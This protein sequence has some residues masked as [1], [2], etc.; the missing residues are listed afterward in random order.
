M[1]KEFTLRSGAKLKVDDEAAFEPTIALYE[2]VVRESKSKPADA[3]IIDVV[4]DS[5]LIRSV[6]YQLFPWIL[7]K[8]QQLSQEL[9]NS[10][11][12][13]QEF[14]RDYHEIIIKSIEVICGPF[15]QRSSSGS[16]IPEGAP[17]KS[18]ALS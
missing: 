7:W 9:I 17:S 15:F 2:T 3:T 12:Y 8:D 6:W 1:L 13:Q 11:K 16:S 14:K 4:A 18:P 10:K 5:P